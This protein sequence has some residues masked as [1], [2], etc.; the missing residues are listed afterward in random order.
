[1]LRYKILYVGGFPTMENE[2]VQTHDAPGFAG[3]MQQF[4]FNGHPYLEMARLPHQPPKEAPSFKVTGK[5]SKRE[6]LVHH[7]VTFRSKH[8]FVGLPALKAY[9]TINIYFQV[10]VQF[11]IASY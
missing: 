7:P 6:H 8:T 11:L 2:A 3:L 9:S 4:T 5:F 1:M 10:Y